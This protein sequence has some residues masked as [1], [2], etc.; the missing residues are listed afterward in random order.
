[1]LCFDISPVFKVKCCVQSARS[2]YKSSAHSHDNIRLS[3]CNEMN[4]DEIMMNQKKS[5]K[6]KNASIKYFVCKNVKLKII[7]S[8]D[9]S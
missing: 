1:M 4:E 2:Q 8:S 9:Q 7:S 6:E 5:E 3:E